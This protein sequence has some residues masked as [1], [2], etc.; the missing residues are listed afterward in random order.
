VPDGHLGFQIMRERARRIDA[1]LEVESR[2]G[3]GSTIT[4]IWMQRA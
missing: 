3:Q 1:V 2:P 4:A